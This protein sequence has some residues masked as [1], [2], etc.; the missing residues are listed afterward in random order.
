MVEQKYSSH[1]L[2]N[3][4][5]PKAQTFISSFIFAYISHLY[6]CFDHLQHLGEG[7]RVVRVMP[8]LAAAIQC[9]VAGYCLG[10]AATKDDGAFI[11]SIMSK[12]GEAEQY[13]I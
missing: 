5:Q 9:G 13:I 4:S 12:L 3:I 10:S 11:Y 8:N 1:Y 2:G 7:Q 6:Y